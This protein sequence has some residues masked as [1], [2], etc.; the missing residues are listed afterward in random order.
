MSCVNDHYTPDELESIFIWDCL[1][2]AIPLT[3]E[4]RK[5][6]KERDSASSAGKRKQAAQHTG[7]SN[8]A[9]DALTEEERK[10]KKL[11]QKRRWREAH[12]DR[13][14][15]YDIAYREKNRDSI[16][17]RQREYDRAKQ[18]QKKQARASAQP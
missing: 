10:R 12:K 7:R 4:E 5:A 18:A 14:R 13:I 8:T 11:E 15:A 3:A 1:C 16:N 6:I 9:E 2:E 17:E